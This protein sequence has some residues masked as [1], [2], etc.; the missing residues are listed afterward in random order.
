M[1]HITVVA[2]VI[3]KDDKIFC[4]QRKDSGEIAKKWEFP[5]GKIEQGETPEAALIREIKEELTVDIA[6][7]EFLITVNHDYSNFSITMHAYS[8]TI[9]DGT[10]KLL[11]HIDSSWLTQEELHRLD[12]AAADLPIVER[13]KGLGSDR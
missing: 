6:V 7:G 4:A 9:L 12:W 11:E 3:K 10:I 13:V 2:A 1:K 8:A 5:G